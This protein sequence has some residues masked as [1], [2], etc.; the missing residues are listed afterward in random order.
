ML[1]REKHN[2]SLEA[3]D[4]IIDVLESRYVPTDCYFVV[5]QTNEIA[6]NWLQF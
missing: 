6:N 4:R 2:T 1:D 5:Q 3:S